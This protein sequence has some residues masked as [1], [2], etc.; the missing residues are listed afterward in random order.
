M[1]SLGKMFYVRACVCV[2]ERVLVA[3]VY[4]W[5]DKRALVDWLSSLA[6]DAASDRGSYL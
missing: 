5:H 1:D 4:P 3:F 2:C 6:L